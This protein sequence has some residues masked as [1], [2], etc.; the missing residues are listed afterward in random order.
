VEG[1]VINVIADDAAALTKNYRG[2]NTIDGERKYKRPSSPQIF[3]NAVCI[4]CKYTG[5]YNQ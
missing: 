5:K 2:R 1:Y 3:C 4:P